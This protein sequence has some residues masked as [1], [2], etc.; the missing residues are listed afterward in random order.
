MDTHEH[1]GYNP[2]DPDD[3][4]HWISNTRPRAKK[5]YTCSCCRHPIAKGEKH[6]KHVFKLG[7][8]RHIKWD[9]SHIKCPE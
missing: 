1:L 4:V 7:N 2:P 6:Y 8:D 9:R 5:E 3:K